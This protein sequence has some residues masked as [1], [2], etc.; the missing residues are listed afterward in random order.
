MR[1]QVQDVSPNMVITVTRFGSNTL[2]V[3]VPV[4]STVSEVLAIAG[5]TTSGNE[6]MFVEGVPANSNSVL[7]NGDI[8]SVVTPKQ[9]G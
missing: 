2:T 6:Q 1:T 9:M 3:L 4:D 8:L 5:I 7:E